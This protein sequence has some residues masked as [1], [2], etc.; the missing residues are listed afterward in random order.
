M[1]YVDHVGDIFRLTMAWSYNNSQVEECTLHYQVAAT[2]GGDSR[3]GML[4]YIQTVV[5]ANIT[6]ELPATTVFYGVQL[7]PVKT[8]APWA[9]VIEYD[10]TVGGTASLEIPTQVRGL[11]SWHTA[12]SGRAYRGRMYLPTP[13]IDG[14][15]T[16]GKP[17]TTLLTAWA[18]F[19]STMTTPVV[20]SGTT[21]VPG[22]YHRVPTHLISSV[23][24]AIISAT[25]SSEFA[26]QRRSGAYGRTNAPPF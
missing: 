6:P 23:F 22:I 25:V 13:T 19:A 10:G 5:N 24:D 1:A 21:W 15:T 20:A 8:L 16:T 11:I 2:S 17:T 12:M 3:A 26:T 7:S 18:S 4:G 14:V 9:P